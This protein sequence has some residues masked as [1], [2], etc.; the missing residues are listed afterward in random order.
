[1]LLQFQKK[2]LLTKKRSKEDAR[3]VFIALTALGEKEFEKLDHAS[4]EQLDTILGRLDAEER[5]Q[6]L[7][8][9]EA[10]RNILSQPK[11]HKA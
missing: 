5:N 1:L 10:V 2:K 4:R 3:S 11:I 7:V 8:H 6:L 9:L